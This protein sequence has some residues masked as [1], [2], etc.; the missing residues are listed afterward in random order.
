MGVFRHERVE[1]EFQRWREKLP[2]DYAGDGLSYED[3]LRVHFVLVDM[4]YGRQSGL[5]GIGPKSLDLL[6]SA[7]GRQHVSFGGLDKW[8]RPEEIVATLLYGIILNHP[9]HDANKR[10][11]FLSALLLLNKNKLTIKVTE[12]QFEDFTVTVA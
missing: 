8:N 12:R 4:F 1:E 3:V 6:L 2:A 11:A 9:F 10:T 5:G 7:L